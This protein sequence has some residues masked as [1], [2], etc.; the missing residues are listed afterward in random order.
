MLVDYQYALTVMWAI[1]CAENFGIGGYKISL[2]LPLLILTWNMYR[3]IIFRNIQSWLC[4]CCEV[5]RQWIFQL[6]V[7]H[8]SFHASCSSS[9]STSCPC[10]CF[11]VVCPRFL[12]TSVP[13][14]VHLTSWLSFMF[15]IHS[16]WQCGCA[17]SC[18]THLSSHVARGLVSKH[19]L[20]KFPY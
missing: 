8:F 14:H 7:F 16:L 10:V 19:F 15:S 13:Y 2:D 5:L 6:N 11:T 18:C 4:I 1:F 3:Q 12:A 17:P 9:F 20:E